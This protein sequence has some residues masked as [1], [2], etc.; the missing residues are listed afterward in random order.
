MYLEVS[1]SFDRLKTSLTSTPPLSFF[2]PPSPQHFF[3]YNLESD[4]SPSSLFPHGGDDPQVCFYLPLHFKRILLTILTCP[5]HI[6]TFKNGGD[7]PQY[8]LRA[9]INVSET[10]LR[11]TYLPAFDAAITRGEARGVMCSYNR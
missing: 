7:D 10:D 4:F 3:A 2:P 1:P 11:Q 8:R 9:D 5:P 6:L